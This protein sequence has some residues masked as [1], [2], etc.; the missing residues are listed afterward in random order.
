MIDREGFLPDWESFREYEDAMDEYA[1]YF[2]RYP[3]AKA[4]EA[5]WTD[6]TPG[7]PAW[8]INTDIPHATFDIM[9]DGEVFS[10]GI[11]V[12]LSDI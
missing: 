12:N 5:V 3:N 1:K 4:V 2:R 10:R 6:G 11:V 7:V 9:E 8:T